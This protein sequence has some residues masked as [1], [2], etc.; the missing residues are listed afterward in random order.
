[1]R[2]QTNRKGRW[3]PAHLARLLDGVGWL[4]VAG[5]SSPMVVV[6]VASRAIRHWKNL[7][8]VCSHCQPLP[9]LSCLL[10]LCQPRS[11]VGLVLFVEVAKDEGAGEPLAL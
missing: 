6:L 9:A 1:M 7:P 10:H 4:L 3:E 8:L 5:Y 2:S 11:H